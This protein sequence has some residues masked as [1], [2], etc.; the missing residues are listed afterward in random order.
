M[1]RVKK[2]NTVIK[3]RREHVSTNH[4]IKAAAS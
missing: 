2:A 3:R 1:E 4:M